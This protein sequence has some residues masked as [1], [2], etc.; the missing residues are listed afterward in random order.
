[1]TLPPALT[2][3]LKEL[4]R[5]EGATLFMTLL[6]VFGAL[7]SRYSGQEEIV[8]GTPVANRDRAEIEGIIGLF[9]NTLALR[10][11][12]SGDPTVRDAIRRTKEIALAAYAHQ[13]VPFEKLVEELKPER[14]LS[15]NPLFQ[16][17]FS[18]QNA[19]HQGLQLSG[20]EAI[21]FKPA[22]GTAKFDLSL[23]FAESP[24]GLRGRLEY[25]TDLFDA[26]T[27]QRML[28]HYRVLLEGAVAN[29]ELRLSQLP[30]LSRRRTSA[31]LGRLQ[32]DLGGL[33]Q[34][35]LHS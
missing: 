23:F 7:L 27:V 16:V 20:V 30:L 22:R 34:G 15:H 33:S 32:Q 12:L 11:N 17:L 5:G 28:E 25:N 14:S 21:P 19:P 31:G 13:D 35:P 9:A 24:E 4:G 2:E 1:M 18:L 10:I 26:A 8:V 3:A 6:A 29:P